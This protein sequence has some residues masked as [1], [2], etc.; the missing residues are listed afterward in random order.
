MSRSKGRSPSSREGKRH[1]KSAPEPSASGADLGF[2]VGEWLLLF[3]PLLLDQVER[4]VAAAERERSERAAGE[5]NPP[6]DWD[7]LVAAA[8]S[9][10]VLRRAR[11]RLNE[12]R[13]S[14]NEAAV[15]GDRS[16]DAEGPGKQRASRD[17]RA[18]AAKRSGAVAGLRAAVGAAAVAGLQAR[19]VARVVAGPAGLVG[20]AVA[21]ARAIAGMARFLELG[22]ADDLRL[23]TGVFRGLA[24]AF[25]VLAAPASRAN[26]TG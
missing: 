13:R 1:T 10:E 26:G 3:H 22:A 8:D 25:R 16:L 11:K 2:R 24:A 21:A 14:R 12:E 23:V 7:A 6:D 5:G 9:P 15:P 20:R 18:R 19:A 4:L 17:L